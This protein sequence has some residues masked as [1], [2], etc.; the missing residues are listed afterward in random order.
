[1]THDI[2]AYLQQ[3]YSADLL[4][5]QGVT[6]PIIIHR[7]R[8]DCSLDDLLGTLSQHHE[9]DFGI[10]DAEHLEQIR[11]SRPVT[12][13][14]CYIMDSAQ[15]NPPK[16]NARLGYYFDM[17]AT[18]D[19]LDHELRANPAHTPLRDQLHQTISPQEALL[20][21]RGRSGTIGGAVLTVF[22]DG[23]TYR[24]IIA[25]RSNQVA[26]GAGKLHVIPAFIVQPAHNIT[27]EWSLRLHI[28]REYAEEL[29]AM[30]EYHEWHA[31]IESSAYFHQHPAIIDLETMLADGRAGL[32]PT[33]MVMNLMSLR[34]ELCSLLVIHD[35]EWYPRN[36]ADLQ[37]A[38][39]TER[40][41]TFYPAIDDLDTLPAG[42]R[43]QIEPQGMGALYLGLDYLK[44]ILI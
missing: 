3:H 5:Y 7:V 33:G 38:L 10:Y 1:M 28:L 16:L 22:N 20:D 34:L 4:T 12:N 44:K 26:T 32:Y 2:I 8:P 39:Q 27:E 37:A 25:Q 31:P 14:L 36:Q 42:W 13:G 35:A 19:A 6:Y 41:A 11:S 29:F 17:L 24:A 30:P 43:A 18:C 23:E 40:L 15:T 9:A 21:G